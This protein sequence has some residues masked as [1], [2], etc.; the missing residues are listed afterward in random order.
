MIFFIMS[1]L[2]VVALNALA[3]IKQKPALLILVI[4]PFHFQKSRSKVMLISYNFNIILFKPKPSLTIDTSDAPSDSERKCL[5]SLYLKAQ[6]KCPLCIIVYNTNCRIQTIRLASIL[7]S[8]LNTT[9]DF[10]Y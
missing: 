5:I 7:T 8:S 4:M 3:F 9:K 6:E 1:Q 2:D 10:R